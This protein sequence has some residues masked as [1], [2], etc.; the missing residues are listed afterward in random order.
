MNSNELLNADILDILFDNRNKQYGAYVLRKDYNK[1]MSIALGISLSS[2]FLIIFLMNTSTS[3]VKILPE[4]KEGIIL[5]QLQ[6]PEETPKL[7]E[8]SRQKTQSVQQQVREQQYTRI[9]IT[10]DNKVKNPMAAQENLLMSAISNRTREGLPVTGNPIIKNPSSTILNNPLSTTK[11]QVLPDRGPEFPGG[12]E[13]WVNFL[14][15]NLIAPAELE[16]DQKKT[17]KV[18]FLVDADGSVTGFEIVETGGRSFDNE[19]IRVL[20]KMPKWKPAIQNGEPIAKAFVQPVTFMG[21]EQ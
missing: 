13:A 4:E 7:P 15:K 8:P 14:R 11:P 12:Q 9:I 17:V 3:S 20:K 18:R 16:I 10:D 19:V 6:I 21:V 5:R 2:V 1:R